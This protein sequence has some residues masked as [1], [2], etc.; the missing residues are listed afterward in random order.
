MTPMINCDPNEDHTE[1]SDEEEYA[2]CDSADNLTK[3]QKILP[4]DWIPIESQS[5]NG[6]GWRHMAGDIWNK[7]HLQVGAL[8]STPFQEACTVWLSAILSSLSQ[9]TFS[10]WRRPRTFSRQR[11]CEVGKLFSFS[12]QSP[13]ASQ[14]TFSSWRALFQVKSAHL[15]KCIYIYM[16][17]YVYRYVYI[18]KFIYSITLTCPLTYKFYTCRYAHIHTFAHKHTHRGGGVIEYSHN[19]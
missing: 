14:H 13:V 11:T 17:I 19:K 2:Q 5:Q 10:R 15:F 9:R 18:Y 1:E 6:I 12:S 4:W 16:Y 3:S 8:F 7:A